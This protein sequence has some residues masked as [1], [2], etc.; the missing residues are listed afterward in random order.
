[1]LQPIFYFYTVVL[2][3][4][5][6]YHFWYTKLS[7]YITLKF[8]TVLLEYMSI[9]IINIVSTSMIVLLEYLDIF[10]YPILLIIIIIF[11]LYSLKI[12]RVKSFVEW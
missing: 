8:K 3:T 12:L 4:K 5:I 10:L 7:H 2:T 9:L 1:M 6:M 11:M